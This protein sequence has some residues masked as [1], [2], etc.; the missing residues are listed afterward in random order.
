NTIYISSVEDLHQLSQDASFDQWSIGKTVI[1]EENIDLDGEVFTPIPIFAGTFDG[2][3][4]TIEGLQITAGE[5]NQGFFRYLVE[6]GVI[7]DLTVEG[8]VTPDGNQ[9]NI[10]G[11]VGHNE[12][13]VEDSK[14]TGVIKGGDT[15]GG[16]VGWNGTSANITNSSFDGELYGETK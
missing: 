6:G 11:I 1:L 2:N 15:V 14:F 8:T 10:G 4:H 9:N 3:G 13:T 5:S 12:G 7:K 16:L